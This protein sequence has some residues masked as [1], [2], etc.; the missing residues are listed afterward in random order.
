MMLWMLT[1]VPVQQALTWLEENQDKPLEE[2]QATQA[3]VAT[4][5]DDGEDGQPSIPSGVSAQS[6]VCN[7]CGKKFRNRDQAS[8]HASKT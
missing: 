2:L 8:F 6:L 5:G 7:E 1:P 4:A 3:S